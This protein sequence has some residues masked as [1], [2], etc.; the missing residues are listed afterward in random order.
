[1]RRGRREREG[2]GRRGQ[3]GGAE[4]DE[5]CMRDMSGMVNRY[6][7]CQCPPTRPHWHSAPGPEPVPGTSS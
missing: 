3:E 7:T 5:T 1:M 2:G 4:G 6:S